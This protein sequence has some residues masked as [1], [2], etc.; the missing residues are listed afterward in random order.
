MKTEINFGVE[1]NGI[2]AGVQ[3]IIGRFRPADIT[4]IKIMAGNMAQFYNVNCP[5][6]YSATVTTVVEGPVQFLMPTGTA[7]APSA[8]SGNMITY[9]IPDMS[10]I[11]GNTA[12][13]IDVLTDIS[14]VMGSEVCITTTVSN[15]LA[16]IKP[17]NNSMQVCIPVVSSFDPNAKLVSP[18]DGSKPGDLLTYT[19]HFQNTG[20][21]TAKEIIIR[22]T[23][24]N[25]LD[26]SSFK[27]LA[28]SHDVDIDLQ[29]NIL[30]F[31]FHKINL[32]DSI[33]HEPQSHGW[34]QF[35]IRLKTDLPLSTR[36]TN[37]AS[38]YF[39]YNP[40][41]LT[42]TAI[43]YIGPDLTY[44]APSNPI[45]LPTAITPNGDGLNDTWHILN[46]AYLAQKQ[47]VVEQVFI[48][49][50]WGQKIFNSS[51]DTFNWRANE[52]SSSDVFTYYIIY[53]TRSGTTRDQGGEITVVR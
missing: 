15:V 20:S 1:C 53:R 8:V 3:S 36:T 50:R 5:A 35:R 9:N 51:G 39:D 11:D 25:N 34:L 24:S 22:D 26:L 6:V 43:N 47:L 19:I 29:K 37:T 21:D 45:H 41:I 40:P 12:F 17:S 2:D 30:V 7:I 42:D 46:P 13:G 44:A 52:I 16:D 32:P 4:H 38:I 27:F 14:A 33:H 31:Y 49:N 28:S 23:L 18:V 48:M 10:V